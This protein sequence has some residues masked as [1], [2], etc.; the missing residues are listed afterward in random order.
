MVNN[1]TGIKVR[2]WIMAIGL[3]CLGVVFMAFNNL[4][5]IANLIDRTSSVV[6]VDDTAITPKN[7]AIKINVLANDQGIALK[8]NSFA[9]GRHG[10]VTVN[11]NEIVY[12]PENDFVG[13]DH[14]KY[15]ITNNHGQEAFAQVKVTVTS[16]TPSP[17]DKVQHATA[18]APL[19][20]FPVVEPLNFQM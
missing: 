16:T 5:N 7:T 14:F 20:L 4:S 3:G 15:W 2:L 19:P 1:L 17:Q 18:S 8:I 13:A 9:V 11:N 6:A 12:N 10:S